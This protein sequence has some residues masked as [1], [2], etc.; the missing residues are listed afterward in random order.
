MKYLVGVSGGVDSV[1]LLDMLSRI[2]GHELVVAHFDHGIRDDSADDALFVRA[3]AKKYSLS[4]VAKREELGSNASEE[5][6]R[7]RRYAFLHN[8]AKKRKA[9]VVTAHHGDDAVETIAIN[10]TR[11]TGWRGAAVLDNELVARPLLQFT[12]SD[13][14]NYALKHRLE[15]VE[16]AT[17]QTDKYLR[18]RTRRAISHYISD[19]ARRN[20]RDVR[21]RQVKLKKEIDDVTA[22]FIRDSSEYERYFFIHSD[23]QSAAEL[24]RATIFAGTGVSPTRPQIERALLAVKT[25]HDGSV[26][27]VTRGARLRFTRRTF[28]V[29]TP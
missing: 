24:L 8:E 18:N 29:E 17:N 22:V 6:A 15:W 27:E 7:T 13:L 9:K 20:V 12:K 5:L 23:A 26:F 14:I 4:F 28:I 19:E 2:D 10:L 11:G 16:D 3:L 25:A 21:E 1:V